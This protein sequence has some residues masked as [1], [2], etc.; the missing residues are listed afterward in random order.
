M[1]SFRL[2]WFGLFG[3]VWFRFV[4]FRKVQFRFVSFR[5][6]KYSFVSFRFVSQS[7]GSF[8]F[9][10]FRFARY[11]KPFEI[12]VSVRKL[13]SGCGSGSFEVP[14]LEPVELG[15]AISSAL[16]SSDSTELA[17]ASLMV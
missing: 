14:R 15:N 10:S 4:S 3:L 8:R 11:S 17:I 16:R 12:A 1:V 7:T 9:V 2:V 13:S 5:F 6:A